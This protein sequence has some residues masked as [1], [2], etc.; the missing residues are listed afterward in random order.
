MDRGMGG[1]VGQQYDNKEKGGSRSGRS[2]MEEKFRTVTL[3]DVLREAKAPAVI[4]Y[5]SLDIEGAEEE[6]LSEAA[7]EAYTFLVITVERPT[8][9]LVKRMVDKGYHYLTVHGTFGDLMF[10]HDS[11]P[12]FQDV[13]QRFGAKDKCA[14]W[15][16][17]CNSPQAPRP[18]KNGAHHQ[19]LA[20]PRFANLKKFAHAQGR[21]N[22][23]LSQRNMRAKQPQRGWG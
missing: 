11:L 10:V 14:G 15:K 13:M 1:I 21:L 23:P 22:R 4:D 6:A 7:L 17:L 5:L 2:D 3:V 8:S 12:S 18:A 19:A 9:T 20:H 16:T